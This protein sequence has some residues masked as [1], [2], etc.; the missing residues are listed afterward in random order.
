M[1]LEQNLQPDLES[2]SRNFVFDGD[3]EETTMRL[4]TGDNTRIIRAA[5]LAKGTYDVATTLITKPTGIGSNTV[6]TLRGQASIK[7]VI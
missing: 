7:V 4:A 2:F 1:A 6:K 5:F 3:V